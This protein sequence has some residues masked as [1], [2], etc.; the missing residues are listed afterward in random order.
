M[1]S[2]TPFT[3]GHTAS[4]DSPVGAPR[5]TYRWRG[6]S[7]AYYAAGEGAPLLLVHSI[8]AAASA[9]EMRKPFAGLQTGRRVYALD[10]LG[11][12]SSDRPPRAYSADEYAALIGDFAR[13][14]IG[15]PAAVVASSLGAAFTIRAAARHQQQ[16]TALALAC[17]TGVEQL[18]RP[19]QPGLAYRLLRGP[20]GD[21][22]FT[23]L[24][25]RPGIRLFLGRQAY[26]D[27]RAIDAVTLEGFHRAARQPGAKYAPIC[28]LTGLL[29]C[30][31]REDFGRLTQPVLLLWGRQATTTPLDQARAF[32]RLNPR[33]RLTVIDRANLLI[34]DERPEEFQAAV[35]GFLA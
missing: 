8:N 14:V 28:F 27:P 22:V 32:L 4:G 15:A 20:L 1:T 11:Y 6:H 9:F 18:V 16:F 19:A 24:T 3:P 17:P 35:A 5:Q 30:D 26:H 29:N 12:G 10:L 25:S 34:Q 33:A 31:V 2:T 7:I 21:L 23:L 13:E